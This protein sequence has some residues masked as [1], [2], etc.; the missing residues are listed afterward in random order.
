MRNMQCLL[1]AAALAGLCF[2]STASA[3]V[4]FQDDFEDEAVGTTVGPPQIGTW[5]DV[6]LGPIPA[7]A[8]NIVASP[9]LGTRSMQLQRNSTSNPDIK[10]FSVPGAVV[11]GQQVE[12]KWSHF[13]DS[14]HRYNNP[15]QVVLGQADSNY[16][17]DFTFIYMADQNSGV[18]AYYTGPGQWA[19][20]NLTSAQSSLQAWDAYRAVLKFQQVDATTMGG[21]MDI[22]ASMNGGAEVQLASNATMFNSTIPAV[23]PTVL[24]LRFIK[25]PESG[26]DY[27]DNISATVVP[28]PA[29]MSLLGGSMCGLLAVRRLRK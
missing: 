21:T 1:S 19:N 22:F 12:V 18:I 17:N 29:T 14:P 9:A 7:N 3:Q 25:G 4:L 2:A 24:M 20:N 10:G 23:D 8:I 16:N 27:Y 11:D 28:E 26:I 13:L 15:M 5:A 6:S